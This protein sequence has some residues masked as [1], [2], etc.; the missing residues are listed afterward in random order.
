MVILQALDKRA[1]RRFQN[2]AE[3][4][5]AL[6]I[7]LHHQVTLEQTQPARATSVKDTRPRQVVARP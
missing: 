7:A 3:L 2:G 1:E 6:E 5:A 4:V